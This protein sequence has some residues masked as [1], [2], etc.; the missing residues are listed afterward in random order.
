MTARRASRPRSRAVH[1]L[2]VLVAVAGVLAGCGAD[3]MTTLAP[4]GGRSVTTTTE[5]GTVPSVMGGSPDTSAPAP[6]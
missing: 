5:T 2:V 6:D 3:D 4:D 1:R